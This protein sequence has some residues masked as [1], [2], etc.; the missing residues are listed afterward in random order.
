MTERATVCSINTEGS[1]VGR[2]IDLQ[3]HK[4]VPFKEISNLVLH[5]VLIEVTPKIK[6]YIK[7][8]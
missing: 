3:C 6:I 2:E 8:M 5:C 7:T 4:T 1:L